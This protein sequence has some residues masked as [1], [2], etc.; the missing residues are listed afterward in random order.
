MW[1]EKPGTGAQTTGAAVDGVLAH[2]RTR[3][4]GACTALRIVLQHALGPTETPLVTST[5]TRTV[6]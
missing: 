3:S 1:R 6:P 2:G 5:G 4:A